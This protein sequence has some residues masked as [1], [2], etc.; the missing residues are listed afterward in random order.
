[1]TTFDTQER[2]HGSGVRS[3]FVP[4]RDCTPCGCFVSRCS[5]NSSQGPTKPSHGFVLLVT[6][7]IVGIVLAIGIS[8]MT[9]T[10]KEYILSGVARESTIALN[11][12]DAGMECAFYWDRASEGNT[13]DV[14]AGANSIT[15]MGQTKNTGG[16]AS[17]TPQEFQFE[18]GSPLV[19]AKISVTKYFSTAGPVDMGGGRICPIGVE[20]TRTV[21][22]GYN[23]GCG[24][25]SD[26]RAVERGLRAFY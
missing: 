20:C 3:G 24:Q 1:M 23:R 7:L 8:I 22:L 11:A 25:L 10:L 2:F 19:C 6:I 21:S 15:C 18:W 13:F 14:G 4:Y 5:Q 26:P 16:G 17:G 12:A 9:I